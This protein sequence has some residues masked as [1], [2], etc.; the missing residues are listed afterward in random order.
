MKDA[1]KL[2]DNSK[3]YRWFQQLFYERY[4]KITYVMCVPIYTQR[5]AYRLKAN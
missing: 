5:Q 3:S 4:F 2:I 1:R